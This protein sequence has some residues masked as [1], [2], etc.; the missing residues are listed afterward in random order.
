[1]PPQ[2]LLSFPTRRS[3][4]LGGGAVIGDAAGEGQ[5][6]TTELGEAFGTE[7]SAEGS[8][9]AEGLAEG[10]INAGGDF[11]IGRLDIAVDISA[12]ADLDR[13]ST[14]LNSSHVASSY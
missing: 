11:D 8:A 10:D 5:V 2:A 3:S 4:D 12:D 1:P 6:A 13:K 14:R 7:V 9:G